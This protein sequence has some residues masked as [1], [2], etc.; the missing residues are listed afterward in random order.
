MERSALR[1][2]AAAAVVGGVL[3]LVGNL[4]HPRWTDV[5]DAELYEK[6]ADSSIWV[7]DH[8]L[9]VVAISLLVGGVTALARSMEGGPGHAL[10]RYGLVATVVG[11]AVLLADISV[12][13]FAMREAAENFAN[14]SQQDRVGAFWAANAIENVSGAMFNMGTI[15]FIGV[16]PLLLGMAAVR[17]GRYPA[18]LAW[19]AIVGGAAGILTGMAGLG[20]AEGDDLL[21]PFLVASLLVT[22]WVIGAGWHLW[23]TVEREPAAVA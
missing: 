18:A 23:R 5:E 10:A 7:A 16:S 3:G 8:L 20:G 6:I 15:V 17:T 9:L 22:I 2:G 14:A 13:A 4:A 12:D 11:G 21:V 19:M 1:L